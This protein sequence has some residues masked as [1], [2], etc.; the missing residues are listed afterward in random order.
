MT[1]TCKGGAATRLAAGLF[2][3]L[4]PFA[5]QAADWAPT[6]TVRIV[7]PIIGST[8]DALARLV[9]PELQKAIGQSVVVENKGGAGGAI[10]TDEVAKSPPDGHT[11]LV[12]YNGPVAVNVSLFKKLP[13]DPVKDLAPIT[14]AVQAQQLLV[15]HPSVKANNV[16]ELVALAKTEKLAYGS[17]SVGS[18]SHLTM[19]LLKSAAHFDIVH[20]PYKGAAPAVADLIGGQV[21][22]AFLVPGNISQFVTQGRAKVIAVTGEHRLASYPNVPTLI[23]QGYPGFVAV[24]WIGFLAPGGTPQPIIDRYN[25]ELVKI[26]HQPDVEKKLK[27]MEFEVVASSPKQ[28]SDWIA[29]EI[30]RWGKVV[31]DNNIRAD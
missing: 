3:C 24:S 21:Q 22:A 25:H 10:G 9:Q 16:A 23:E 7:V 8:N 2:A 13:Y 20:V 4:L 12:G 5:A 17:V 1:S 6:K 15:V 27:D 28:F 30:K 26:L 14:L 18:N 31:R 11:L 19:E 29:V